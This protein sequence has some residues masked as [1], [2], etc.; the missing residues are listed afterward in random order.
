M[1]VFVYIFLTLYPFAILSQSKDN[2]RQ[3]LLGEW[4]AETTF[5]LSNDKK[6]KYSSQSLIWIERDDDRLELYEIIPGNPEEMSSCPIIMRIDEKISKNKFRI[7]VSEEFGKGKGFIK[8]YSPDSVKIKYLLKN[9]Q[10][11]MYV[12]TFLDR[13]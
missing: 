2:A 11:R 7:S 8:F 9:R 10:R 6:E 13:E 4:K 1:R 12:E 3:L 5:Y